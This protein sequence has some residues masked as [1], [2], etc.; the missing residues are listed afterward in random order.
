MEK[1][2]NNILPTL[3]AKGWLIETNQGCMLTPVGLEYYS[4]WSKSTKDESEISQ[5]IFSKTKIMKPDT[6]QEDMDYL[7]ENKY[8]C[9]VYDPEVGTPVTKSTAIGDEMFK[10]MEYYIDT[11]RVKKDIK[12]KDTSE[13]NK[14]ILSGLAK[15][16]EKMM[17]GMTDMMVKVANAQ[18]NK[19]E[20][21]ESSPRY[22]QAP[23]YRRRRYKSKPRYKRESKPRYEKK[24][25]TS[26]FGD[27]STFGGKPKDGGLWKL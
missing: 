24:K 8:I 19:P 22:R 4:V 13:R 23:K 6:I 17:G 16:F 14:K 2:Y 12:H 1:Q 9:T 3:I 15:G 18:N 27:M 26:P 5:T 25:E 21:K 7:F 11:A 20:K 10:C